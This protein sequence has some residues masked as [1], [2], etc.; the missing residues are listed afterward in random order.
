M[1]GKL[2]SQ[3]LMFASIQPWQPTKM[4]ESLTAITSVVHL[5]L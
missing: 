2:I 5:L 3:G 4:Y 1:N